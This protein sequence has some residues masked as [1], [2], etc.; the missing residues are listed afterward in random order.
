MASPR[1]NKLKQVLFEASKT[2]FLADEEERKL[3]D[4]ARRIHEL[5][6]EASHHDI[7]DTYLSPVLHDL[8]YKLVGHLG[9]KG[10]HFRL[11][12]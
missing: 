11:T 10:I 6:P 8:G 4:V 2:Y 5:K 3:V 9:V 12:V 7:S 1:R